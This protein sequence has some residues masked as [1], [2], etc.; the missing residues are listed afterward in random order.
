MV[1]VDVKHYVCFI[2]QANRQEQKVGGK[3]GRE[4]GQIG[5]MNTSLRRTAKKCHERPPTKTILLAHIY[6]Y[7]AYIQY[8]YTDVNGVH[9]LTLA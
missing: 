3:D 8:T 6:L 9:S 2:R 4:E 7:T 1:S 5:R